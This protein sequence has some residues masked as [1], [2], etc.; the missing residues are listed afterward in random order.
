MTSLTPKT[1]VGI[2]QKRYARIKLV[3]EALSTHPGVKK[4]AIKPEVIKKAAQLAVDNAISDDAVA[5]FVIHASKNLQTGRSSFT[6]NTALDSLL[7]RTG[8][9]IEE[10]KRFLDQRERFPELYDNPYLSEDE[11][12]E[13][14]RTMDR[15]YRTVKTLL[16]R[17]DDS[18]AG[19][20]I[21]PLLSGDADIDELINVEKKDEKTGNIKNTTLYTQCFSQ[22]CILDGDIQRAPNTAKEFFMPDV[23]EGMMLPQTFCFEPVEIIR[24]IAEGDGKSAINPKTGGKFSDTA[25]K[26]INRQYETEAKMYKRYREIASKTPSASPS[27]VLVS[28]PTRSPSPL[29][30]RSPSPVRSQ[31]PLPVPT[32][33]LGP[34]PVPTGATTMFIPTQIQRPLS[35]TRTTP[36][37][38]SIRSPVLF[39]S[40]VTQAPPLAPVQGFSRVQTPSVDASGF[41][42]APGQVLIQTPRGTIPVQSFS[43]AQPTQAP[44]SSPRGFFTAAPATQSY[45]FA[46]PTQNF[47]PTQ[48]TSFARTSPLLPTQ[49]PYLLP[50]QP[51]VFT[52]TTSGSTALPPIGSISRTLASMSS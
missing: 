9:S 10:F 37:Q 52:G 45:A 7:G 41:A 38:A 32:R 31:A 50:T 39:P 16:G 22:I 34:L 29:M 3:S 42:P 30:T 47:A 13:I 14:Q 27:I 43:Q 25:F 19:I 11:K 26:M 15:E 21:L 33:S 46:A 36:T 24:A 17:L 8:V 5:L 20:P 49:A 6:F 23:V 28:S 48:A 35:P 44:I 51:S 4:G 18:V 2:D 1:A 40:G 12:K